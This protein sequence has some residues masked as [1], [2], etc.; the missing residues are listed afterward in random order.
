MILDR[1]T[2]KDGKK[3]AD[4]F[5]TYVPLTKDTT[6]ETFEKGCKA[7]YNKHKGDLR[8]WGNVKINSFE[9]TQLPTTCASTCGVDPCPSCPLLSICN[10]DAECGL[11]A[12]CKDSQ[13]Y[14]GQKW[15]VSAAGSIS[16][17]LAIA[18]AL[19]IGMMMF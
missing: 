6:L 17:I 16:T 12:V 3:S 9:I 11:G 7:A 5:I 13:Q 10:T 14:K 19:I 8:A 1:L 15:C 2:S 18:M 4:H